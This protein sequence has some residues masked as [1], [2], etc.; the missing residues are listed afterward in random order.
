MTRTD[1][2]H[3]DG[4]HWQQAVVGSPYDPSI[5]ESYWPPLTKRLPLTAFLIRGLEL[6][7]CPPT[8]R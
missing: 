4:R 5:A 7:G 6:G 8:A 1:F 3:E 2:T